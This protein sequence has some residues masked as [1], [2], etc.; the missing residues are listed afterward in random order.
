MKYLREEIG[1]EACIV[2]KIVKSP[3]KWA[4]H[5]VRMK[6]RRLPKICETN[7]QRGCIKQRRPQVRWEDCLKK[8]PRKADGRRKVERKGQQQRAIEE[9]NSRAV[10]RR[11]E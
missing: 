7:K 10:Q 5:M 3:M 4:G 1:T 2:G 9:N 8:D 11:D 6:D